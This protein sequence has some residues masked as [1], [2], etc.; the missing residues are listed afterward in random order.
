MTVSASAF[1]RR[2]LFSSSHVRIISANT[3]GSIL[4]ALSGSG[5]SAPESTIVLCLWVVL[6]QEGRMVWFGGVGLVHASQQ[7]ECGREDGKVK[8]VVERSAVDPH[9][10]IPSHFWSCFFRSVAS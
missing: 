5:L 9:F 6:V 3:L 7:A 10:N 4:L 8:P 2:Y 1:D